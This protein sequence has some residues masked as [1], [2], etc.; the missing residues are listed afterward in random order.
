M[1]EMY[2]A[3]G[4]E[5]F[6]GE[7]DLQG[8]PGRPAAPGR[9]HANGPNGGQS[10][11]PA[12]TAPEAAPRPANRNADPGSIAVTAPA[13]PRDTQSNGGRDN[14]P[15]TNQSVSTWSM[16]PVIEM[17]DLRKAFGS[18]RVL[19]GAT[20]RIPRG[21][22]TVLM[23]PSGTGKSVLLRHVVGLLNPDGG[24]IIVEGRSVPTL[25]EKQILELR[26]G[27]GMLFQDGALF[28]SM[29]LYD[30]VAFPL[31][32]H[33]KHSESKIRQIVMERLSEVGLAG[34]EKRMPNEL[35]GGMRKR[36]GFARALVMEPKILLFDEPDSGLD[37]VRTTLL[38]DLI[39]EITEK[40]QATSIV[41]SHDVNAVRRFADYIGILYK[42]KMR[43]F[44]T[45]AEIEHSA[46]EFVKQFFNADSE[47]PLGMD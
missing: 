40:Y 12:R 42:G 2:P 24:D 28:S 6:V 5:G 9:T 10:A 13:V 30:N 38:C 19:D 15:G 7:Q 8:R 18:H 36:A 22:V 16:E 27:I 44:G 34:A 23:G 21:G 25:K 4:T 1:S 17:R 31:R 43:H 3:I 45:K 47:G 26:R 11:A 39:R 20:C 29:N 37:P 46:D 14:H 35:S 41:I 32:Q 33:T